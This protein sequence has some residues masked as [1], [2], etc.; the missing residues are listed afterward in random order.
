[1]KSIRF[2]QRPQC[3]QTKKT[4]VDTCLVSHF[5]GSGDVVLNAVCCDGAGS[6]AVLSGP[7]LGALRGCNC[8]SDW[9]AVVGERGGG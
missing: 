7:L 8:K 5:L 1:M 3:A 4:G 6:S 9:I 2:W